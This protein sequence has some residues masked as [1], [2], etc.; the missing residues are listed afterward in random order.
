M[1][2]NI[3]AGITCFDLDLS[4]LD[5]EGQEAA[6][7]HPA[8]LAA[9]GVDTSRSLDAAG[10][11]ALL[12]EPAFSSARVT[13]ELKGP[14]ARGAGAG[15]VAALAIAVKT[16]GSDLSARVAV[17]TAATGGAGAGATSLRKAVPLRDRVEAGAKRCDDAPLLEAGVDTAMPSATCWRDP[18]VRARVAA[19]QAAAAA[20]ASASGSHPPEVLVWVADDRS[21]ARELIALGATRVISNEPLSLVGANA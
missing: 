3:K 9:A 16:A 10:L 20:A 12:A 18:S 21:T 4:P 14:L 1:A 17:L 2:A 19:W 5:D 6:V 11:V 8:A 13:L 7:A 15:G